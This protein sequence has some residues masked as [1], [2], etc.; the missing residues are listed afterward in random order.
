M[1]LGIH[2]G[3]TMSPAG[4][5]DDWNWNESLD[6]SARWQCQGPRVTSEERTRE[7]RHAWCNGLVD[8]GV[9]YEVL[10]CWFLV[11]SK[12]GSKLIPREE[13]VLRFCDRGERMSWSSQTSDQGEA[14]LPGSLG[15]PKPYGFQS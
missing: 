12:T 13:G 5:G 11:L 15:R 8:P 10:F 3:L 1:A 4:K 6:G 2:G 7:P 14:G 9:E